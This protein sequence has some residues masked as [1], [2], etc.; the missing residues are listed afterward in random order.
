LATL[1]NSL[2][3]S[4]GGRTKSTQPALTALCGMLAYLAD[5]SSWAKVIPPAAL[6]AREPSV[7]SEAVPDRMTLMA[8]LPRASARERRK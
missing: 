4:P 8:R 6:M 3:I 1:I 5:S 7:P 2:A